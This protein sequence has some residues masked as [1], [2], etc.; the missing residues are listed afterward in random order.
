MHF[1]KVHNFFG[2]II[3]LLQYI[4]VWY[5]GDEA[6]TVRELIT[7][8]FYCVYYSLL[9]VSLAMGAVKS[10]NGDEAIFLIQIAVTISVLAFKLCVL[11]WKQK[12]ILAL[13]NQ[14][15]IFSIKYDEDLTMFNDKIESFLKFVKVCLISFAVAVFF[16]IAVAP[17]LNSENTLFFA[18][19]FPL[20]WKQNIITFWIANIF[21]FT[22]IGLG[23]AP[24]LFAITSWYL[25][26]ICSLRYKILQ[27]ELRNLGRTSDGGRVDASD[28]ASHKAFS[29]DLKSAI[30]RHLLLRGLI[31][32]LDDFCSSLFFI[33]FGTGSL[34]ICG[35][36]YCLAFNVSNNLVESLI[37][38]YILV[39]NISE[40]FMITYFGNEIMLSSDSLT[41]SLFESDWVDQPQSTKRSV[42]VFAEYLKQSHQLMVAKL[43]PLNLAT[44]TEII[45]SAY[46]MF[47]I[48]KNLKN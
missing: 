35:S 48:L 44:F 40:I 2:K 28:E 33:Q 30:D 45:R 17:F 11:I 15:S 19:A 25:M 10:E 9:V 1:I 22:E 46:S 12:Q 26:L 3:F 41:Y 32:E 20:D 21:L 39:Y 16:E 42:M 36:I 47:N 27:G 23:V 18:I 24:L 6:T 38:A 43:Y 7:K 13:F 4:G 31:D 5:R 29:Q 14:I 34:F 37:H 8:W